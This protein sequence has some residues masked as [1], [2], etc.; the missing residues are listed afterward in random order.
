MKKLYYIFI[1]LF[2]FSCTQ[3]EIEVAPQPNPIVV[4]S[5]FDSDETVVTNQMEIEFDLPQDGTYYLIISKD[6]SVV[7]KEKFT[8][9]LGNHAHT[10]YTKSL[11]DENYTLI[12]QNESNLELQKTFIVLQK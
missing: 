5:I 10:I 2:S 11:L 12:L 1:F 9:I 3:D 4:S 8:G 6:E 7:S